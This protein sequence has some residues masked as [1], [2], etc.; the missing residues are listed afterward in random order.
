M[1]DTPI[2]EVKNG[3]IFIGNSKIDLPRKVDQILIA[4]DKIIYRFVVDGKDVSN[5][6]IG[7]LNFLGEPEWVIAEV[8]SKAKFKEYD[9][10]YINEKGELIACCY[11]GVDC[12]VDTLNGSIKYVSFQK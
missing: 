12:L 10:M 9:R 7:A 5:R 8:D 3:H 4:D 1:T 2:G 11:I 6:N